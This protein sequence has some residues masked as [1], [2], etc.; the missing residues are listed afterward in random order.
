MSSS[1]VSETQ[2]VANESTHILVLIVLRSTRLDLC[3]LL[4]VSC[5]EKL[6]L[7]DLPSA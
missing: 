7:W 4:Q 3:L 6:K 1:N 5:F 2:S